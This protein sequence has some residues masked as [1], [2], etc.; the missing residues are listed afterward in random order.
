MT[1]TKILGFTLIRLNLSCARSRFKKHWAEKGLKTNQ[2]YFTGIVKMF[3]SFSNTFVVSPS[4]LIFLFTLCHP[5]ISFVC[6]CQFFTFVHYFFL[7]LYVFLHFLLTIHS[8]FAYCLF[9]YPYIFLTS[10]FLCTSI[11][12]MFFFLCIL[13]LHFFLCFAIFFLSSFLWIWMF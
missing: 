10:F 11:F 12:Y 9:L 1:K 8:F 5:H 7:S 13:L 3:G 2:N 6:F 4:F